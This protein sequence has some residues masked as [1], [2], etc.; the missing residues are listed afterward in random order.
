MATAGAVVDKGKL[1][2]PW[3]LGVEVV[4]SAGAEEEDSEDWSSSS[5]GSLSALSLVSSSSA[6]LRR[7]LEQIEAGWRESEAAEPFT[8]SS[9]R[10]TPSAATA[11]DEDE[12]P[13]PPE[14]LAGLGGGRG[15]LL[16]EQEEL[17]RS[18][19]EA[20]RRRETRLVAAVR[21]FRS[22]IAWTSAGVLGVAL[23]GLAALGLRLV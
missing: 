14:W 2:R 10:S 23:A 4:D 8:Q 5:D 1:Y 6:E 13:E 22:L 19:W 9:Q 16:P 7:A 12:G 15:G 3:E 20:G 17:L 11:D 18:L 21:P